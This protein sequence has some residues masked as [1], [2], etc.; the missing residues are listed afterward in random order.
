MMKHL[1]VPMSEKKNSNTAAYKTTTTRDNM[2]MGRGEDEREMKT[3][4]LTV[5]DCC[6]LLLSLCRLFFLDEEDPSVADD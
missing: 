6:A 5:R 1:A 4:C 3:Q 2:W